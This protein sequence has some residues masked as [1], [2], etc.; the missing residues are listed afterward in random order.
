[1]SSKYGFSANTVWLW[2]ARLDHPGE[3]VAAASQ[4]LSPQERMQAARG[5][6]DVARRRVLARAALR[7]VLGCHTGISPTVVRFE[8]GPFGKPRLAS[9][10]SGGGVQFNLSSTGDLCLIAVTTAE[11]GV[12]VER[13]AGRADLEAVASRFFARDE[14]TA[15]RQRRGNERLRAL[16][17]TWTLKEALVKADGRGL[18]LPLD[19]FAVS[20]DEGPQVVSLEGG[21]SWTVMTLPFGPEIAAAVALHSGTV[22]E[23]ALVFGELDWDGGSFVPAAEVTR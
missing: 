22:P 4:L 15:I 3:V 7:A 5:S 8:Y 11:V 21:H 2:Q 20:I 18:T 14:L 6:A 23:P 16:F 17:Q 13:I 9:A 12:D 10:Q 19:W 1:V